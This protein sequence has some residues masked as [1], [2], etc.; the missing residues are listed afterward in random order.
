MKTKLT[1]LLLAGLL[2]GASTALAGPPSGTWQTLN[3]PADFEK[4]KAGDKILYVCNECQTVTEA[5]VQST[6]AA[7]EHCKEGATVTC[8]SCKTKVRVVTKGPPKNPT[9]VREVTYVNEKG[10]RCF[11]IA[12]PAEKS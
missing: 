6:A 5:T 12:K 11:F 8:P 4:L 3:K 1:V 10:E 2:S 9:L 7:M